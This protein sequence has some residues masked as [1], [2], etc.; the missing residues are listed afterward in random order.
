LAELVPVT[1]PDGTAQL[2]ALRDL[3]IKT[4]VRAAVKAKPRDQLAILERLVK[5]N[6]LVP[7]EA[8]QEPEG[9]IFTEEHRR[10]MEK[11]KRDFP[12]LGSQCHSPHSG[13]PAE[14]ATRNDFSFD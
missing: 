14:V 9:E 10:I 11:M 8:E 5:L 4:L 7:T 1:G 3:L 13:G 12:E 2:L 6:V